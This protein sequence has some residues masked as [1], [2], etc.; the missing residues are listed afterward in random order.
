MAVRDFG[1]WDNGRWAIDKREDIWHVWP[2][3]QCFDGQQAR[4]SRHSTFAEAHAAY[5]DAVTCPEVTYTG[6]RCERVRHHGSNLHWNRSKK[7]YWWEAREWD[8]ATIKLIF[9]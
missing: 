2:S 4:G 7:Q 1:R 5:L 3:M 9:S 8:V 6:D